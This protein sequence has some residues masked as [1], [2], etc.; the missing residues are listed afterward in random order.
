MRHSQLHYDL[1]SPQSILEYAKKLSG[2]KLSEVV[3][4]TD[5]LED[6][7]NKGDLGTM[8]EKYFFQHT[9]P[10]DHNPDFA[11]A[12]LELKT[13][14]VLYKKGKYVAKERLVL[15]MIDYIKLV[16][17]SWESSTLLNKCR[18]ML[19][20]FYLYESD[21]PVYDRRFVLHPMLFQFPEED[22]AIIMQDWIT[23]QS[24]VRDGKAEELSEGDTFYLAACRKGSGGLKEKLRKQPFSDV[25]AKSRAF[26]LK[27]SYMTRVIEH[28]GQEAEI[29]NSTTVLSQG[30][31]SA[32]YEKL[33]QHIGKSVEQLA[34]EFSYYRSGPNDKGYFRN[35]VMRLFDV[36]GRVVPELEKAGVIL[37]TVRVDKN[38]KPYEDMSFRNFK[39][40]EIVDQTWEESTFFSEIEQK[41]LF[42]IYRTGDDGVL[43]LDN[44][45]YWN[46]PYEDRLEAARVW[47]KAKRQSL[48]EI[49]D[50]PKSTE[51]HV[52]HVRPKGKNGDSFYPTKSGK[53]LPKKCFWLNRAY[54][55]EQIRD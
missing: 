7:R 28:H 50:F 42:V 3:D 43:R 46:M 33:G 53:L 20:L 16:E 19:L 48:L 22:L 38:G 8:V 13:T 30:I 35:L 14:G 55:A 23:I 47:Q 1:S 15:T 2:K 9:P 34:H 18:L 36:S 26:S 39:Y 37:K 51:S 6:I 25:G 29:L 31:I 4:F 52:A 5:I 45:K 10:N 17:E 32:T 54:I 41:F 12:G 49:D 27:P 24:K 11:E 21:V 40:D 44:I